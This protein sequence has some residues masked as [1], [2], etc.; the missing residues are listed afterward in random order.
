MSADVDFAVYEDEPVVLEKETPEAID[1]VPRPSDNPILQEAFE[2]SPRSIRAL[3]SLCSQD[4]LQPW[5]MAD[6]F[7]HMTCT[8]R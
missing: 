1:A 6:A 3:C 4:P 8:L 7:L 2:D 5:N